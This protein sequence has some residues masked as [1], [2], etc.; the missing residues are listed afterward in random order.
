MINYQTNFNTD[1]AAFPNT[2]AINVSVPGANDGTEF[3]AL[4]VIDH[5]GARQNLMF[6]AGLTPN[7]SSETV[8]LSQFYTCLLYLCMPVGSILMSHSNSDPTTLGYRF[9]N[10]VGGGVLRTSYPD[11]DAACYV[12]DGNNG[13]ADYWYRSDDA[14]GT[15]RNIAGAYIQIADLRGAFV[16]GYDPTVT[17]DP[18]GA[19][20]VFPD[21]QK[22]AFQTHQH[23]VT[24][25]ATAYNAVANRTLDVG[26]TFTGFEA[27]PSSST[28]RL[29]A[30]Q[31][32][33]KYGAPDVEFNVD[34]TRS[35]NVQVKYWIRY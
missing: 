26:S 2:K 34:E 17:R 16:R 23:E 14:G 24:T 10:L 11:L 7:G 22:F 8:G 13:S 15:I 29:R 4:M 28:I 12:G 3:K 31:N 21:F 35:S 1:G 18:D 5:W 9:L 25:I 6:L 20:R 30:N 27:L 33:V 19:T 32:I